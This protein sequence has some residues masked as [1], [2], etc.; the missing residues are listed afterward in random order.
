[1]KTTPAKH[2]HKPAYP[3]RL[4]VLA[5]PDL[6]KKN[7]PPGWQAVPQMAGSVALFLAVNAGLQAADKKPGG[8]L[9]AAIVAPIFEHGDGRGV[10]GCVVVSPPVFL[11]EEEA[12]QVI[13]EE[14]AKQG[15]NISSRSVE[16]RGVEILRRFET[17]ETVN[18]TLKPKI[19][20]V[21]SSAK[22]YQS[23][24]ADT[25][26]RVA[27]EFVSQQDYNRLGVRFQRLRCKLTILKG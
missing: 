27:V 14:L 23:D 26:K 7:L 13:S 16:I 1:M 21:P 3:T 12:W 6:L 25:K 18:G 15:V 11:S 17:Y 10:T 9:G 24:G 19:T 22:T 20:E 8:P 4:E 2:Y 5:E